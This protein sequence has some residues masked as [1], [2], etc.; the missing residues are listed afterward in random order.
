MC[1]IPDKL[2]NLPC[3]QTENCSGRLISAS[4]GPHSSGFWSDEREAN[5]LIWEWQSLHFGP[6]AAGI[7]RFN[8]RFP[9]FRISHGSV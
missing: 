6:E 5:G 3:T 8:S 9:A 2:E 4:T 7:K 1:E